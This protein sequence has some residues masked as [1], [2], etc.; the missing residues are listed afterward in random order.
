MQGTKERLVD[1][2]AALLDEGGEATV[3]LRAVALRVG[4]SHNAPYKHFDDRAALLAGVAER[5]F[6]RFSETFDAIH[7]SDRSAI[8]KVKAA[9]EAFIGYGESY[10]ARYRLLFGDPDIASAGGLLPVVAMKTFTDFAT[11]IGEAQASHDLPAIPVP[12]L[13][14]LIFAQLHGLLDL[15]A[16]GRMKAEKGFSNVREGVS[17]LLNLVRPEAQ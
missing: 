15:Q 12:K 1:A 10:P 6:A 14:G 16:G 17:L 7:K 3:T 11:L 5:D 13:T 8:A 9:L 4:V 2:A